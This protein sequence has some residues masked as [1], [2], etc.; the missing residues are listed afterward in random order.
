MPIE[1]IK[2]ISKQ[3]R[4]HPWLAAVVV[5]YLLLSGTEA[6]RRVMLFS[7][8]DAHDTGFSSWSRTDADSE[9]NVTPFRW[10]ARRSTIVRPVSGA[11]LGVV[12]LRDE[13]PSRAEDITVSFVLDGKPLDTYA[14]RGTGP[15]SFRYFLPPIL[16]DRQWSSIDVALKERLRNE[17]PISRGTWLTRWRELKPWRR[18]PSLA[19][20]RLD[21]TVADPG[22]N[23]ALPAARGNGPAF[24]T[25]GV[26]SL[27]WLDV[28]PPEGAGFHAPE[29]DAEG[30]ELRWTRRWAALPLEATGKEAI[31]RMRA[32]HPN[33]AHDPV[34]VD[35]YWGA[36]LR[37]SV[38][39]SEPVWA[40]IAI[41][42]PA[43]GPRS[44]VLSIHAS[45][46]W[47]PARAGASAD[48][49]ELGVALAGVD[50][51]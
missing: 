41:E 6:V 20:I 47:S 38:S 18:P 30:T 2:R 48:A 50:S 9:G 31:V 34:I 12:L 7:P 33:I 27:E 23:A 26:A 42:I 13:T 15:Y 46:T 40:E 45:R 10:S 14:L 43:D 28:L 29:T 17:G 39:L 21:T 3:C 24:T 5:A 37:R 11:V 22:T 44:G 1:M 51:R 32:L 16:G 36:D 19:P 49:R 25:V 35:L 4:E 8:A